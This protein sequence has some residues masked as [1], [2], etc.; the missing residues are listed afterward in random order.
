MY[1][2]FFCRWL[3][4]NRGPLESELTALPTTTAHASNNLST[5]FQ[6]LYSLMR[7]YW[8]WRACS[9]CPRRPWRT[10]PSAAAGPGCTACT[11]QSAF[12]R[13]GVCSLCGLCWSWHHRSGTTSRSWKV[14]PV[15]SCQM[16]VSCPKMIALE[17]LYISTPVKYCQKLCEIS[18]K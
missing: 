13:P 8:P 3:D 7:L 9:T 12:G 5:H 18:T 6:H 10:C 4:S 14:W 16:S 2:I 17:K 11:G 1:N 15:K